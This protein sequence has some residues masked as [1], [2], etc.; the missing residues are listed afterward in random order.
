MHTISTPVSRP[1]SNILADSV[2]LT[3]RFD[4]LDFLSG[5]EKKVLKSVAARAKMKP[6]HA[7]KFVHALTTKTHVA[8]LTPS[9]VEPKKLNFK[10]ATKAVA[11]HGSYV[12]CIV[13]CSASM[14]SIGKEVKDG[15]NTFVKEQRSLPGK[16]LATVVKFNDKV[17]VVQHGADIQ[18]LPEADTNTFKPAGTTAL[19]DAICITIKRVKCKIDSLA[20]KP[21]RVIVM[22]LTDGQ[23]NSSVKYS[24][25][26]VI[27]RIRQCEELSWTFTF[28]GANQDAIATGTRIGFRA[29]SCLSYTADGDHTSETWNNISA[30]CLRQRCGESSAWMDD[31]RMTSISDDPFPSYDV[32]LMTW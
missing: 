12:V 15:F 5:L 13:D 30:N 17:E 25:K 20:C 32:S 1:F 14:I 24:N 11:T 7:Y 10:K 8:E 16:C 19:H 31:E 28:I 2:I 9:K 26:D 18:K 22:V 6:G 3:C 23:E 4:D 29:D 27:Q 21:S